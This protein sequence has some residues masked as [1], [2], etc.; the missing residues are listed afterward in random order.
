MLAA[1]GALAGCGGDTAAVLRTRRCRQRGHEGAGRGVCPGCQPARHRP[2]RNERQLTRT[3][4]QSTHPPRT[5]ALP[6]ATASRT[7]S[8]GS[9]TASRLRSPPPPKTEGHEGEHE[10]IHSSIEVLP[11]PTI[12]AKHNAAQISPRGLDCIKRFFPA[13]FAK[14][15]TRR[16]YATGR[17]PSSRLSN[18]LP[19]VP[20]SF[21]IRI[22]TKYPRRTQPDRRDTAPRLHRHP[23]LPLRRIRNQPHR[24]RVPRTGRRRSRATPPH[25]ALRPRTGEQALGRNRAWRP[26]HDPI[27]AGQ[28]V[29]AHM[30]LQRTQHA[31]T[32]LA[33]SGAMALA[34]ACAVLMPGVAFAG[35]FSCAGAV[36]AL[37]R[38]GICVVVRGQRSGTGTRR[39]G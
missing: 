18:P 31:R 3:R 15:D 11:T 36:A 30:T 28:S 34:A 10:E 29:Q 5:R 14:K 37:S 22:A 19:D 32:R 13:A 1:G 25:S 16:L 21:A 6:V 39:R 2:A 8:S 27:Q 35:G 24:H 33:L 7:R 23:R 12:A 9:S 4:R 26:S 38:R 17:S 20:G